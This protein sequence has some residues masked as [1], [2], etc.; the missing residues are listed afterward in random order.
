MKLGPTEIS[1]GNRLSMGCVMEKMNVLTFKVR[2][3]A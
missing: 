1:P 3:Y 2:L